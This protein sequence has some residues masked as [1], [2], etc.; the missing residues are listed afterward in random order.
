MNPCQ[1]TINHHATL[2]QIT[3]N[4]FFSKTKLPSLTHYNRYNQQEFC[5]CQNEV[6]IHFITKELGTA[7]KKS[8]QKRNTLLWCKPKPK[9]STHHISKFSNHSILGIRSIAPIIFKK[10]TDL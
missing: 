8:E 1:W 2:G 4:I 6:T 3:K 5:Q 10:S 7:P 9:F